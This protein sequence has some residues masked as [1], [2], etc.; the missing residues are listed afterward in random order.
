M[1]GRA[2]RENAGAARDSARQSGYRPSTVARGLHDNFQ[3]A[4]GRNGF[5]G[6]KNHALE[7]RGLRFRPMPCDDHDAIS[8]RYRKVES[9]RFGFLRATWLTRRGSSLNVTI[10]CLRD[11]IITTIIT[12]TARRRGC[13]AQLTQHQDPSP[14]P[15]RGQRAF[16]LPLIAL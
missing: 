15:P 9:G 10:S 1:A 11:A 7:T 12:R 3:S 6:Y 5:A 16:C 2:W 4:V 14:L 8:H 13:E